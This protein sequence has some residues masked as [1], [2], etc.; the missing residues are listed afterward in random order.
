MLTAFPTPLGINPFSGSRTKLQFARGR[1]LIICQS[2][3]GKA[4]QGLCTFS[5][6]RRRGLGSA[7][8]RT[9]CP[10]NRHTASPYSEASKKMQRP[11][12]HDQPGKRTGGK[13]WTKCAAF[14]QPYLFLRIT[15]APLILTRRFRDHNVGKHK[16]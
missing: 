10:R 1:N 6:G 13:H 2:L 15:F 16:P 14:L 5:L 8:S 11:H 7:V 9:D 3:V 12:C 4:N